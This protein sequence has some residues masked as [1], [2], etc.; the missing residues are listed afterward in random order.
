VT[1]VCGPKAIISNA[2]F[3]NLIFTPV[4][5]CNKLTDPDS[6]QIRIEATLSSLLS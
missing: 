5:L 1:N 2:F 4:Y 3:R 6:R